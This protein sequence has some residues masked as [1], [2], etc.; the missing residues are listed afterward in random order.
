MAL[1]NAQ[2]D[3]WIG[4][5][6]LA[7]ALDHQRHDEQGDGHGAHAEHGPLDHIPL[8]VALCCSRPPPTSRRATAAPTAATPPRTTVMATI[9][10]RLA[11]SDQ[12]NA[13]TS[14]KLT[15]RLTA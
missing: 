8:H 13:Q 11:P 12:P 14:P 1:G 3:P 10:A 15:R 2:L 4:C 6:R 9:V 7:Q 5:R